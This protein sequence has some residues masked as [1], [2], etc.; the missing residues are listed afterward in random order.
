MVRSILQPQQR[1]RRLIESIGDCIVVPNSPLEELRRLPDDHI[2]NRNALEKAVERRFAGLDGDSNL[3]NHVVRAELTR[4]LSEKAARTVDGELGAYEDWVR[5]PIYQKLLRI[6]AIVSGHVF[7]GPELCRR[8]GYLYANIDYTV[9]VFIALAKVS[10]HRRKARDFL[11]N[12]MRESQR[13]VPFNQ[14]RF[15]RYVS[16]PTTLSNGL[17][18]LS[19]FVIESSHGPVTRDPILYPNPE[20]FNA[21]RFVDLRTHKVADPISHKNR[22]KYQFIAVTEENMGFGYSV[23]ACP[24]GFFAANEIKLHPSPHLLKYDIR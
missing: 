24:G 4:S 23:H 2:N 12:V 18:I 22:E 17:H 19:G 6:V 16:K 9:D 21:H 20:K 13:L 7:L 1:L 14:F 8:E 5:T 3:L 15:S 11:E 10:E